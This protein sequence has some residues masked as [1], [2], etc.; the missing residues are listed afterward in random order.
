MNATNLTTIPGAS[1]PG[2]RYSRKP[3]LFWGM[4]IVGLLSLEIALCAWGIYCATVGTQTVVEADY[5]NKALHWDD[6]LALQRASIELGWNAQL[7]IGDTRTTSGD[8][9]LTLH[10][11]DRDGKP[12][13]TAQIDVGY[14]H[15][16]RPMELRTAT[17]NA[18]GAGLY[19]AS[20]PLE[21]HGIWEF[22][23]TAVRRMDRFIQVIQRDLEQ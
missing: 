9:A 3:A 13:E 1:G 4:F 20:L 17:L 14:F 16:A 7:E 15:H 22:R 5:Y 11:L 21:R 23:I 6:H 2:R 10:L 12:I 19:I 18:S 8:R